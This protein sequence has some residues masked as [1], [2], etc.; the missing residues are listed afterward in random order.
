MTS[1]GTGP[2]PPP[3]PL[4]VVVAFHAADLL[5]RCLAGLG[6]A[7]D[8]L[9]VDNSSDPGVVEVAARHGATY[10]APGHNLG[11][12]GGVNVGASARDGRDVLLLNPDAVI[13]PTAVRLL[14][15]RLDADRALAAVAPAQC[16]PDDGSSA[17]VAWP[18]PTPGGAWLEAV[19]FGRLRRR[20]DFLIGSILLIADRAL[21]DVGGFDDHYFLYAEE[22]DWQRRAADRGWRVALCPEVTATHVG[23]GTGGDP[24][25]RETHF[26]A[27]HERYVRT[28]HGRLGWWS[29][30]TAALCGAAVRTVVLPGRRRREAALRYRLFRRG[31]LRAEAELGRTGMRIAHLVVTE[32]FAG[33]E[34]YICQVA[35]GLAARG[36]QVDV[37]GG[38]P[39]R[40]R[41]EM[42][43]SV[44]YRPAAT[45]AQGTRALLAVRG[46]D[47]V[48]A[49]MTAAE[50]CATLARPVLRAPVVA[51]RHFAAERGSNPVNR[52]LARLTTR[53]LAADIAISRFVADSVDGP[54]ELIPNGV[55]S[56]PQAPLDAHVVVMLQRLDPEK[57]PDVGLRAWAASGL[58]PLGWRLVVAGSGKLGPELER[59]ARA[60]GCADSVTFAGHVADTDGLLAGASVLLAPAPAEPFGL[61]VVEAMSH[62]LAVVAAGGGAHLE[63][64]GEDG[65]CFP[66]GDVTAAAAALGGLADDHAELVAVGAALR[67]RQQERYSIERH[68]DR[69]EALYAAVAAGR[70]VTRPS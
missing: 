58:G 17:R 6:G 62:G 14:H 54:T 67:R 4:V 64:V 32:N 18:F 3:D 7:F 43:R 42:D 45:L 39:D 61:S 34:R 66:P 68:L 21:T 2:P 63:T 12:A 19:G 30:R 15:A 53:H 44:T 29:Y 23:A 40:M 11:F 8:V 50:A 28:H 1:T 37:I 55:A 24:V 48:H 65:R 52:A 36:H 35:D 70:T 49:H 16:D 59:L 26:Q 60:V 33:V 41:A 27:S 38:T 57:S 46:A 22:T 69:L 51:T 5:D 9:V 56:R 10:V 25:A 47:V 31:P 13:T 20:P